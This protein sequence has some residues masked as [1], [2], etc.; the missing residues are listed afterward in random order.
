VRCTF[1]PTAK[2]TQVREAGT[3]DDT[4][5]DELDDLLREIDTVR[6]P[7]ITQAAPPHSPREDP[8][9]PRTIAGETYQIHARKIKSRPK[10]KCRFGPYS[11]RTDRHL[12][13]DLTP[14]WEAGSS[15]RSD[16]RQ[17]TPVHR[18]EYTDHLGRTRIGPDRVTYSLPTI[19]NGSPFARYYSSAQ[20]QPRPNPNRFALARLGLSPEELEA[21]AS[22]EVEEELRVL[23]AERKLERIFSVEC[24]RILSKEDCLVLFEA[25]GIPSS[26]S[27]RGVYQ[28]AAD[29]GG[30]DLNLDPEG[31]DHPAN[32]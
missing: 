27:L 19:R 14:T 9:S 12:P 30:D 26:G 23:C 18:L 31:E 28:W 11:A 24:S 6:D 29:I 32:D 13:P 25:T 8:S 4:S 10:L 7:A 22:R 21:R 20:E 16:H 15:S 17:H 3:S 5:A 1:G 2:R